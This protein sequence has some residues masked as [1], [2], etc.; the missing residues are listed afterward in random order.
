MQKEA[1]IPKK[2]IDD[3]PGLSKYFIPIFCLTTCQHFLFGSHGKN[4]AL[5]VFTI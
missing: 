4:Y 2:I 3:I 5:P 1:G